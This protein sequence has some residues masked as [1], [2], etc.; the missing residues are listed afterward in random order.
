MKDF[1]G[2]GALRPVSAASANN[3]KK[4]LLQLDAELEAEIAMAS[5][6]KLKGLRESPPRNPP[7]SQI[8]PLKPSPRA[9]IPLTPLGQL[10]TV[11]P[12][13]NPVPLYER[14]TPPSRK[15][16]DVFARQQ[17][18]SG[19]LQE[20]P[21]KLD[22][23]A[24]AGHFDILA[25]LD[26]QLD[27]DF[28][29][30]RGMQ[31]ELLHTPEWL[32]PPYKRPA[33]TRGSLF[34]RVASPSKN[35]LPPEW[36]AVPLRR[37]QS[38]RGQ[39]NHLRCLQDLEGEWFEEMHLLRQGQN[40]AQRRIKADPGVPRPPG[41]CS[42][43][44]DPSP[45]AL[46][47][48]FDPSGPAPR[49]P[50]S[51]GR[52]TSAARSGSAVPDLRASKQQLEREVQDQ[53]HAISEKQARIQALEQA[54][55]EQAG[56]PSA[57]SEAPDL[58]SSETPEPTFCAVA[59]LH[60]F[61]ALVV[62]GVTDAESP[63]IHHHPRLRGGGLPPVDSPV[64][65]R[66][67]SAALAPATDRGAP[68]LVRQAS[69][70]VPEEASPPPAP[71][72]H[73][74]KLV[75]PREVVVGGKPGWPQP[76]VRSLCHLFNRDEGV[77]SDCP[78]QSLEELLAQCTPAEPFID[79]DFV[80]EAP[81]APAGFDATVTDSICVKQGEDLYAWAR[82]E[83]FLNGTPS[84]FPPGSNLE[85]LISPHHVVQ[86]QLDDQ[87]FLE[88]LSI[89]AMHPSLIHRLLRTGSQE[90]QR[91]FCTIQLFLSGRPMEVTVDTQFA[92]FRGTHT[93]C[94]ARPKQESA[95]WAMFLEKA[96]AKLLGGYSG[97]QCGD[98]YS[99]LAD[100]T[101]APCYTLWTTGDTD[102]YRLWM[103]L[104]RQLAD[105]WRIL[106]TVSHDH[107]QL[108][109]TA[110]HMYAM[111]G[112]RELAGGWRMV[113]LQSPRGKA[114]W[115]GP[116]G[117]RWSGWTDSLREALDYPD[118]S[119]EGLFWMDLDDFLS[120]FIKVWSLAINDGWQHSYIDG[121]ATSGGV[122]ESQ[123]FDLLLTKPTRM[124]LILH[125]D[126]LDHVPMRFCL[127]DRSTSQPVGGSSQDFVCAA[128]IPSAH[129]NLK[130][131]SYRVL[132]QV[133]ANVPTN[134]FP[135]SFVLQCYAPSAVMLAPVMAA[136]PNLP[137]LL[138]CFL[139]SWGGCARCSLPVPERHVEA[140][141][142][143]WH[144]RCWQCTTC[145]G[146]LGESVLDIGGLP[147]CDA[148]HKT[149]M[150]QEPICEQCTEVIQGPCT[151][152][153][154]R[155]WHPKC[156]VC[157]LCHSPVTRYALHKGMPLCSVCIH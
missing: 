26:R 28:R 65:A 129:I 45:P 61:D 75:E 88:T 146:P 23:E 95:L 119:E 74:L 8:Y 46:P 33:G 117:R 40:W 99:A 84:L 94:Y 82:P 17:P 125:Q 154:G 149:Q 78:P 3:H 115:T 2:L 64:I 92:I 52:P 62:D 68:G 21:T 67:S 77:L 36:T 135:R 91:G 24:M 104:H 14:A 108:G 66:P 109:L 112:I 55:V 71:L 70:A 49:P 144:V 147:T 142:A 110:G 72:R 86:G 9:P 89:L 31:G 4:F 123:V 100:L 76:R 101:G 54:L 47:D 57:A 116:W 138:P 22:P 43:S 131:G 53:L 56:Q 150:E 30:P 34:G 106:C 157:S 156:F 83:E 42:P 137:F 134:A 98:V 50:S 38:G 60:L 103:D 130:P 155:V 19:G 41:V 1:V 37:P 63:T 39:A 139:K 111:T 79:P 141:D 51:K 126:R 35:N 73:S 143:R 16:P 44:A 13:Y 107:A 20:I 48:L 152:A 120:H 136:A 81:I 122:E 6:G 87:W 105:E 58:V 153:A 10:G 113:R 11:H 5:E 145:Q 18:D 114:E 133:S 93:P 96:Y 140:L 102:V 97:L 15:T 118:T 7:R 127:I 90:L 27:M 85:A 69:A 121:I 151:K 124:A 29:K 59:P 12:G 128:V 25:D 148:C 32:T 80:L 132:V